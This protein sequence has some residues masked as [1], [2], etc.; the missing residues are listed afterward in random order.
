MLSDHDRELILSSY[1]MGFMDRYLGRE[2]TEDDKLPPN[3][4]DNL[5]S[6]AEQ[7]YAANQVRIGYLWATDQNEVLQL[8]MECG[9]ELA[10][11]QL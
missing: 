2:M 9:A 3:E 1:K 10:A 5:T 8:A 11:T 4:D 6:A 7:W